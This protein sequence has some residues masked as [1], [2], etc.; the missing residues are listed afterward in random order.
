MSMALKEKPDLDH[1]RIS[2]DPNS[3][4]AK[5]IFLQMVEKTAKSISDEELA[6][7]WNTR[8]AYNFCLLERAN[9][10]IELRHI[11]IYLAESVYLNAPDI[12]RRA[13]CR[14]EAVEMYELAKHFDELKYNRDGFLSSE[15]CHRQ[16]LIDEYEYAINNGKGS[17]HLRFL[18][19]Q[20]KKSNYQDRRSLK[21]ENVWAYKMA[22][23]NL[24]K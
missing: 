19:S 12:S 23:K 1:F 16:A 24:K 7:N 20:I 17:E 11:K 22:R 14:H 2:L 13:I 15:A 18:L 4:Y 10:K 21:K 5:K 3:P 8:M 6:Q 9:R